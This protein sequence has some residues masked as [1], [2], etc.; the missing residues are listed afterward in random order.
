MTELT[1][2][3][4]R[5]RSPSSGILGVLV[6][7]AT[8]ATLFGTLIA[9]YFYLRLNADR[10]PPQGVEA[11]AVALPVAL[12]AALVLTTAPVLLAAVAAA[13]GRRGAAWLLVLGATVVQAGYLAWQIVLYFDDL[14]KFAPDETTYGSIYFTLLGTH[15][16]HVAIGLL[17]DLWV[18]A[19]VAAGLTS[20]R[21][22]TVRVVAI[23]WVLVNAVA[24]L[25]TATQ[26]SAA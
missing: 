16:I 20:Y 5:P 2:A 1:P 10:W 18:L 23:Y 13:R 17:L 4:S 25:V 26:V 24:V 14:S 9:T 6:F 8:E 11:P 19:R 3:A 15:H 22:T 12:T 21:V 7:A